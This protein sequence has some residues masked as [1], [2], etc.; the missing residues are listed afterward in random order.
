MFYLIITWLGRTINNFDGMILVWKQLEG[1]WICI[2]KSFKSAWLRN[3]IYFYL[4]SDWRYQ[5]LQ[6][7]KTILKA[8]KIDSNP[9]WNPS[10]FW[11]YSIGFSWFGT[12]SYLTLFLVNVQVYIFLPP[13]NVLWIHKIQISQVF[14]FV[15]YC[16]LT[17]VTHNSAKS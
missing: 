15:A 13:W 16:N 2:V 12:T 17:S 1:K 14:F 4:W 7:Y 8:D 3:H 11:K 5:N 6:E 10:L 9:P